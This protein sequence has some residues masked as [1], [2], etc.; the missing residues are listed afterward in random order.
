[1]KKTEVNG[2]KIFIEGV[3]SGLTEEKTTVK[4]AYHKVKPDVVALSISEA[5][6]E[7]LKRIVLG[8]EHEYFLSNYEEIYA[9]KLASFGEVKVPPACY[10]TALRL[11]QKND[12]ELHPI[13]MADDTYT[14]TF[15][16]SISTSQLMRHSLRVKKLRRKRF[17]ADNAED[18]VFEWDK[19]VNKLKG[20]RNVEGKR[21]AYMAGELAELAGNYKRIL[22]LIELQRADG[23]FRELVELKNS[24]D[25]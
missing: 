5:E 13:D 10:E 4:K 3:I 15:C 14:D 19:E 17:K 18:F 11:C 8:E 24:N 9:R 21:E 22:G 23:V 16:E 7:G 12:L 2:C 6:L 1:M 20:F 25:L